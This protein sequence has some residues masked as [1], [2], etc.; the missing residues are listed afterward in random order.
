[1][2]RPLLLLGTLLV[3]G[4][5]KGIQPGEPPVTDI[6]EGETRRMPAEWEPQAAVWL[7]WPQAYEG[8]QVERAFI[9]IATT[10]SEYEDVH[11]V[12]NTAT[13]QD[14]ATAALVDADM[15]RV[16]FHVW[17]NDN[18]WMRDNG[19]RYLE[20]DD[21]LVIQ[22][23]E[24]DAWG[25][26]F[27]VNVPYAADN[28]I[29]DTVADYLGLQVEQ[30]AIV[31]ER[32]DLE[33][34][35]LD[36]AIVSWSVLSHRNPQMPKSEMTSGLQQALGVTSVLYIE[37]FDPL[38]GTRGH[39]DGMVRFVAEDT[40]LVGQD[41]TRLMDDVAEQIAEQR[42]DL[43]IERLVSPDAALFM[44]FLV[45]DGYV[46]VGQSSDEGEN[47]TATDVLEETFPGREIRFVNVDALWRNGGGIHC[48]TND[49]PEAP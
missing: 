9:N 6:V 32:G 12:V 45:G 25:G 15:S 22:N 33:V 43:T 30:V 18:S 21:E 20:V 11:L 42:P 36:T 10:L 14:R 23:W 19:P 44:N 39:V 3:V 27:G 17:K 16:T 8:V 31:H 38:D 46:L 34:N 1:M 47:A 41:G 40:V 28:V 29:P 48:V 37:G 49:Q 35:G 4:C 24:F 26:G 7:Q 13:L 2:T 5:V